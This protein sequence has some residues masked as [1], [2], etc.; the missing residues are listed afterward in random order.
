MS[1]PSDI[2][3]PLKTALD[4]AQ[5]ILV[6]LP[7]NAGQEMVAAALGLFHA[8]S[9]PGKNV[10]IACPSNLSE[11][12]RALPGGDQVTH[13]LGNRNLVISLKVN[14][15]DSID[16][17]SYN[18][19]E[20]TQTFNLIIQPK[21]GNQP[22]KKDDVTYSYSGSQAD[23]IFVVGA[24]RLEDLADFYEAQRK[25]FTEAK[26]VSI[27]RFQNPPYAD[28]QIADTQATGHAEITYD[29]VTALGLPVTA[30]TATNFLSGIDTAT[31]RL[32]SPLVRA[33][34]FEMIAALMKAGGT[35]QAV[36]PVGM[37][38]R[39]APVQPPAPIAPPAPPAQTLPTPKA[40]TVPTNGSTQSVPQDWLAPKIYKSS[41][42]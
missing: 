3:Q 27:N 35:R 23:L 2:I 18:L 30:D 31:N 36:T 9:S 5:D 12:S 39:P 1:L 40:Q 37:P 22:L 19:D 24:N 28:F 32:Q 25:L 33:E 6:I 41:A 8:L 42:Q 17:V 7:Q 4:Q 16:K 13:K 21:K 10:L 29:L 26:T 20:D 38:P 11:G 15:R 14:Q 34:T